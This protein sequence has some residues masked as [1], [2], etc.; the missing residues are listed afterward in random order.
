[1][2]TGKAETGDL[3]K[4]VEDMP[5]DSL[6]IPIPKIPPTK[7]RIRRIALPRVREHKVKGRYFY[8]YCRG[9]DR[10]I[11]LGTADAI[12]RAVKGVKNV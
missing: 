6:D 9:I 10:E 3:E 8:T 11:Y 5:L 7:K 2:I 12:L 1:M 4:L